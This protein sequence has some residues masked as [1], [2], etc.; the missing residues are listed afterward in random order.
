MYVDVGGGH[1]CELYV[2]Y[3]VCVLE[4]C[5]HVCRH[6]YIRMCWKIVLLKC[7]CTYVCMWVWGNCISLMYVWEFPLFLLDE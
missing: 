2:Q 3:V 4:D 7:V 1:L 5:V 6:M